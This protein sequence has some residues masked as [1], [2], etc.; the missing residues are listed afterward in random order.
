MVIT[1]LHKIHCDDECY[2]NFLGY[3]VTEKHLILINLVLSCIVFYPK[4]MN[5]YLRLIDLLN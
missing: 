4:L 2:F 3:S 5:E 1:Y